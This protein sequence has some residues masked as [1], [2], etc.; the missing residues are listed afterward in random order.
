MVHT[1]R[2]ERHYCPEVEILETSLSQAQRR[3]WATLAD[4]KRGI[5]E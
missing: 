2:D 4:S 3:A 1:P 5:T